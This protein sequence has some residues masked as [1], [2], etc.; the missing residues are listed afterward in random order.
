MHQQQSVSAV[1]GDDKFEPMV[2]FICGKPAMHRGVSGWIGDEKMLDCLDEKT[3]ILNYCRNVS[4]HILTNDLATSF[5]LHA[6]C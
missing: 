3:D 2:A 5:L 1:P 6:T 4:E